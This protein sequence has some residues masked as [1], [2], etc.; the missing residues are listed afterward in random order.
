M[1]NLLPQ[2][3]KEALIQQEKR[4]IIFI[5]EFLALIFL[6]FVILVLFAL[7]VEI[8]G[9]L[10]GQEITIALEEERLEKE[11]IEERKSKIASL[12][13]D[14]LGLDSFY[15]QQ[16]GLTEVL[17][18]ISDILPSGIYLTGISFQEEGRQIV[19][20]GFSPNRDLLVEFKNRLEEE[21]N[22][23]DVYFPSSTWIKQ[24]DIDFQLN[25]KVIK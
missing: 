13:A 21:E 12:N 11:K 8:K 17:L 14:I 16:F 22:F 9:K 25:L 10:D 2:K 4:K 15:R 24:K 5:L 23:R 6:L 19:L 18:R 20:L 1:L 3:E 7:S